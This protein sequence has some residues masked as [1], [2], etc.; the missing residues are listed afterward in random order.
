MGVGQLCGGGRAVS[1]ALDG[2][3]ELVQSLGDVQSPDEDSI[4]GATL[5][6]EGR[7]TL[8]ANPLD[9]FDERSLANT[10]HDA[11]A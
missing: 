6:R 8:G 2:G 4:P 5:V 10:V 1:K 3:L 9:K 7:K 11:R